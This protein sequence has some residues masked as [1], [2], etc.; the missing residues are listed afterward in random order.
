MRGSKTAF[1]KKFILGEGEFVTHEVKTYFMHLKLKKR[2]KLL[3][4][5]YMVAAEVA[6]RTAKK[7][8]DSTSLN[9]DHGNV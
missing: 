6:K 9:H 3:I 8:R 5:R 7:P 4:L 1:L 2:S